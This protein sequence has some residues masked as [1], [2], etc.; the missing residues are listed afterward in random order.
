MQDH[1]QTSF[2]RYAEGKSN[3]DYQRGVLRKLRLAQW[4]WFSATGRFGFDPTGLLAGIPISCLSA[5]AAIPYC[6]ILTEEGEP[7]LTP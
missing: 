2:A 3:C 4:W 6:P 5:T 1:D 7:N